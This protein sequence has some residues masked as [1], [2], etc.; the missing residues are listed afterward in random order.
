VS[1]I[2]ASV[3]V[4]LRNVEWTLGEQLA[5]LG[6][7]DYGDPW[8]VILVDNGST[9]ESVRI[10]ERWCAGR[11]HTRVV[12]ESAPGAS[13]ARNAGVRAA[14]SQRILF[15]DADDVVS[16]SWV[17]RMLEALQHFDVVGGALDY[18]R[19][20]AAPALHSRNLIQIDGLPSSLGH[21]HYAMSANLA[22]SRHAYD[23]VGG[24]DPRFRYGADDV[25]FCWRV[26]DRG[27]AIGFAP[28]ALVHY[29][30]RGS[31][32]ALTRQLYDYSRESQRLYAKHR[33]LGTLS[34][35]P[36]VRYK[37]AAHAMAQIVASAP[38]LANRNGRWR[39]LGRIGKA[40]GSCVGLMRYRIRPF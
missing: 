22:V 25:D 18:T 7:Q 8:E 34:I 29:R 12:V 30:L 6:A 4:P 24:F 31:V 10:A 1:E 32:G 20:N 19:L 9:D 38:L 40:A 21:K 35:P 3:V 36:V 23:A 11:A 2:R 39:Y 13:R 15:C 5:A 37:V 27:F 33:S 26:Q 16:P 17:H 14:S 28:D